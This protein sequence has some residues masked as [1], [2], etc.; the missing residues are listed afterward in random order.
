MFANDFEKFF[1]Y[2]F[3]KWGI[4]FYLGYLIVKNERCN[5]IST[6]FVYVFGKKGKTSLFLSLSKNTHGIY[7][8]SWLCNECNS[9]SSYE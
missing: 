5:K 2:F 8:N 9:S 3:A 6:C 1:E 7:T 4:L